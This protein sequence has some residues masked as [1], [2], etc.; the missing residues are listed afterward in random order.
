MP[1][2]LLSWDLLH[3]TLYVCRGVYLQCVY[4]VVLN[5]KRRYIR[6]ASVTCQA[7][8]PGVASVYHFFLSRLVF[9]HHMISRFFGCIERGGLDNYNIHMVLY[10]FRV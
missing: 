4:Q 5:Y 8:V 6:D 2:R 10:G 1:T 9:T 7:S 3:S